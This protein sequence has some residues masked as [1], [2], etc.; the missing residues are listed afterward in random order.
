MFSGPGFADLSPG[1]E[2]HPNQVPG[3]IPEMTPEK[4]PK[5]VPKDILFEEVPKYREI[6]RGLR[7]LRL[8]R[9]DS[10]LRRSHTNIMA[11]LWRT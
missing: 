4:N 10:L 9:K 8:K 2:R 6:V 11:V 1:S 7:S 3:Q 5:H